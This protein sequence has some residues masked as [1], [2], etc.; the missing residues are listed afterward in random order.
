MTGPWEILE[1]T[2]YTA[3]FGGLTEKQQTA[4]RNRVEALAWGGPSLGRPYVDSLRGSRY[5]GLK[6]LRVSSGGH[7][8]ILFIFDGARRCL[9]I[10]GGDKSQDSKW[11]NW[12]RTAIPEA[13]LIYERYRRGDTT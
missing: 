9:L 4:V 12:Y 1:T 6:E 11:N 10:L 3:W 8:R 13:E 2:E 5:S 7:L